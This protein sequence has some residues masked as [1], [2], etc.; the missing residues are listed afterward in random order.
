MTSVAT[1]RPSIVSIMHYSTIPSVY[2]V[3]DDVSSL[4]I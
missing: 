1:Y 3:V 4:D 2:M